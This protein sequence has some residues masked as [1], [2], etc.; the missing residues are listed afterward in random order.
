MITPELFDTI[1]LLV[2][3]PER[4]LRTGMLG[5]IVEQYDNDHFEVEFANDTGRTEQ[6]CALSTDQFIVTWKH[7]TKSPVATADLLAQLASRL[8]EAKQQQVVEFARSLHA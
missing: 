1:E 6:L 5:A 3:I 2:D 8:D 7:D 4:Q